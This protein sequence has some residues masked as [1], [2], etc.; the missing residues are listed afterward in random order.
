M[1]FFRITQIRSSIG[2][3]RKIQGVLRALGLKKRMATVF[4]PVNSDVAGQIMKV[5]ELVAVSEVEQALSQQELREG[6]KPDPGYYIE[7]RAST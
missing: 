4:H 3:P 6:R 7:A 1:P 2:L 5:K